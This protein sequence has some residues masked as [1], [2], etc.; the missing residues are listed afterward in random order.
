LFLFL[1]EKSERGRRTVA[2]NLYPHHLGSGGY[3]GKSKEWAS[4]LESNKDSDSPVVKIANPRGTNWLMARSEITADGKIR[5][6]RELQPVAH[7][8]VSH[9]F[10]NHESFKKKL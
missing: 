8:M 9:S 4:V 6:P 5:L 10:Y 1:K 2:K 7:K 3:E